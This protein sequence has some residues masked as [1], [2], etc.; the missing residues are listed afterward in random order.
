MSIKNS[1]VQCPIVFVCDL[2]FDLWPVTCNLTCDLTCGLWPVTWPV[3]WPVAC[4][5]WPVTCVV[6]SRSVGYFQASYPPPPDKWRD[7]FLGR[8]QFKSLV[9]NLVNSQLIASWQLGLLIP[10]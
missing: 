1:F 5:L 2:W 9:T 4:G 10:F 8:S 6:E 7:L 3:T